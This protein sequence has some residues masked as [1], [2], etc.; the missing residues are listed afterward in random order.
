MIRVLVVSPYS[1]YSVPTHARVHPPTHDCMSNIFRYQMQSGKA[2]NPPQDMEREWGDLALMSVTLDPA[3][4]RGWWLLK[5]TG[6]YRVCSKMTK[7]PRKQGLL[8]LLG[9]GSIVG[10]RRPCDSTINLLLERRN[11][12]RPPN[13]APRVAGQTTIQWTKGSADKR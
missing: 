7:D 11:K 12:N 4:D 10:G 3:L 13:T 9:E 5:L 1:R 2:S 6:A 8:A